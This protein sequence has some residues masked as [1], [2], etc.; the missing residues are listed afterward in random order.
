MFLKMGSVDVSQ[1][2]TPALASLRRLETVLSRVRYLMAAVVLAM[3]VLF[4]PASR[5]GALA[6]AVG[7]L[8][9]NAYV[10][11]A[12][13]R[14]RTLEEM[15]GLGRIALAADLTGAALTFLLFLG[16]PSAMPVAFLPL[17]VFEL[18]VRFGNPGILGGLGIFSLALATRVYTQLYLLHDGAVRTPLLL[19]WT[20]VALL[21]VA[22]SREFRAQEEARL[23]TLRERERIADGFRTTVHEVLAR[24]GVPPDAASR[25]DVMEA[26][27]E[28][29]EERAA[30]Y[31]ALAARIADLLAASPADLGLS[32]RER[33][34]LALLG[35]GYSYG[36][37]AAALFVSPST[38]R[39][40]IHNIK[41]KLDARSRDD[42]VELARLHGLAR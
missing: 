2:P 31:Q 11:C 19:L 24:A 15:R 17:V 20:S 41:I 10:R 9:L 37:I 1:E 22:F 26:V 14:L 40:H 25:A 35:R 5:W 8:A 33:E 3:A 42:L 39:N 23:A 16:D 21:M 30:G 13:G 12:L 29:C 36:R 28:I 6:L 4:E 34:V 27:R 38:V 32:R 18:S 7:P